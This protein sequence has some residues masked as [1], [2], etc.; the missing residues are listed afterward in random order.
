M[1]GVPKGLFGSP[2]LKTPRTLENVLVLS[3]FSVFC[4]LC[5][6]QNKKKNWEPNV[7]SQFFSFLKTKYSFQKQ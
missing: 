1:R 3:G 6:F 7:F 5:V 2:F 4:I